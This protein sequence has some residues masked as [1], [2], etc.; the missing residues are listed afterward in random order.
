MHKRIINFVKYNKLFL[1]AYHFLGN[2]FISI[3]KL[4]V[5][6]DDKKIL[7]MSFGG[8]KYDDSPR[9]VYEAIIKDTFFA[10]YEIIWG[11]LDP[12]SFKELNLKT[13]KVDTLK[14]YITALSARI[15][16]N[17][18]SVERGLNLRRKNTIEFNTWHGTPIKRMG[19]D[20][21]K[22]PAYRHKRK[23]KGTVIYCSQ[24][25]YDRE[26]FTRLFD[27]DKE[28]ILL[29]DLPRIDGF[30]RYNNGPIEEYKKKIGIPANKKVILYAPTFR[31]YERNSMNSCYLK[32]PID[33]KKWKKEL[34]DEYI[35]L[36][37]AHY[38][39]IDVLG[40]EN[41][42]F[43]FNVSDY[44]VLGELIAVSDMM[45]SDYSGMYFDFSV[46]GRPM[47]NFSYDI[48]TYSR[49]RGLYLNLYEEL[50]CEVNL[51]EDDLINEIKTL[52]VDLYSKKC[53]EFKN[54]YAPYAGNATNTVINKLKEVIMQK[55]KFKRS[56]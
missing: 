21:S 14:F 43:F 37:R 55:S 6:V 1:A 41:D 2:I 34:G 31:D 32:P 56:R 5:K 23:K 36:F 39:V 17:N 11:F 3:L 19:D 24:S 27:T 20:M 47:L 7:F 49:E 42:G 10:D 25:E 12:E 30:I 22:A 18:S 53:V 40:I 44:P 4:F 38:E 28:N 35:I 52:D 54:K 33:C 15:W 51:N 50:P 45:V 13:V 9:E 16:I 29:S 46:T 48:D 8:R 26:V